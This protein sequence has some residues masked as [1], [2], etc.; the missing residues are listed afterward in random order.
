MN[1]DL[2]KVYRIEITKDNWG[3]WFSLNY[4]MMEVFASQRMFLM[5]NILLLTKKDEPYE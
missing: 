5:L 2:R 1:T 3:T 4:E